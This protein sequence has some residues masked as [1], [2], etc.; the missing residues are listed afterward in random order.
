MR[1]TNTA[2]QL[3]TVAM[4]H[5]LRDDS[6]ND[7]RWF[8]GRPGAQG[9]PFHIQGCGTP[10][11]AR[12]SRPHMKGHRLCEP[13]AAGLRELGLQL[14][15]QRPERHGPLGRGRGTSHL[16]L[17]HFADLLERAVQHFPH[18][19]PACCR[20]AKCPFQLGCS[21]GAQ[22]PELTY[23]VLSDTGWRCGRGVRKRRFRDSG[24]GGAA[25]RR[26]WRRRLRP[27][28]DPAQEPEGSL[29]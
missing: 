5:V 16:A 8:R 26:A 13:G 21:T 14:R 11:Q 3:R 19:A 25:C 4:E 20:A 22:L 17:E 6:W 2:I 24:G 27:V 15:R 7:L 1:L 29:T 12:S 18:L 10:C 28:R 23:S 9:D